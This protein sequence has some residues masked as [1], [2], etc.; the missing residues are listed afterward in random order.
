MTTRLSD[1][2]PQRGLLLAWHILACLSVPVSAQGTN[3]ASLPVIPQGISCSPSQLEAGSRPDS[4][5]PSGTLPPRSIKPIPPPRL[6]IDIGGYD[7]VALSFVVDT[8]GVID[9][10]SFRVIRETSRAWTESVL[11][12]FLQVRFHAATRE[13]RSVR[14]FT[15]FIMGTGT[16]KDTT[17]A[18][19]ARP[20]PSSRHNPRLELPGP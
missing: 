18:P 2:I 15:K 6:A 7:E 11:E 8:S 9:P 4:A 3:L 13:G 17:G 12:A 10:C 5:A 16:K 19:L 20:L 1:S 14:Y